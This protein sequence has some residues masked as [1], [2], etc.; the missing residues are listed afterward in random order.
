MHSQYHQFVDLTT[1]EHIVQYEMTQDE[2][3]PHTD[4][5]TYQPGTPQA[6]GAELLGEV[7]CYDNSWH[8]HEKQHAIYSFSFQE[9]ASR[10]SAQLLG[11]SPCLS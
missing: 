8:E 7:M 9:M 2:S 10:Q 4:I 3:S 6:L 5:D 11:P 1:K